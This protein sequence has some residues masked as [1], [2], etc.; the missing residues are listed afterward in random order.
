MATVAALDEAA[1]SPAVQ[2]Q[3]Q[4]IGSSIGL[5]DL[6]VGGRQVSAMAY[7]GAGMAILLLFFTVGAPARAIIVDRQTRTLDRML[8]G[9]VEPAAILGGY[10]ISA[11]ILALAGFVTVWLV[12]TFVF[13]AR[14]GPPVSVMALIVATVAAIA[15]VATFVG[16]LARTDRQADTYT[17]IVAFVFAMLGGN[18]L[19]PSDIGAVL[20]RL[21]LLTPNG[22]SLDGFVAASADDAGVSDILAQ[23][24]VLSSFAVFFGGWGLWRVQRSM[25]R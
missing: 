21:K 5:E 6:A 16:S 3:A 11:A 14:W 7:Y 15:G 12:T 25:V 9:P 10:V 2:Q 20:S 17:A 1:L 24:G 19:G 23:L 8:A 18:F 22:W 4:E 13:D